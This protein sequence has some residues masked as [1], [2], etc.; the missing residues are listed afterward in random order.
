MLEFLLMAGEY[1]DKFLFCVLLA[2]IPSVAWFYIFGHKHK[3]KI[4]QI[5]ITF[6]AGMFAGAIILLYQYFWGTKFDVIFFSFEPENFD[7]NIRRAVSNTLMAS[8]FV[9]LS[10]GLL[11]EY[12]KHWV[13]KITDRGI[14]ESI[15]DVIEFSIIGALGFAFLENVGYFF[16]L[17]VNGQEE[18]LLPLFAVRSIFV[19]FVHVLCSG[20]YGYFYGLG[21]FAKPVIQDAEKSGHHKWIPN[22]LHRIFHFKKD[23]VYKEQMISLGLIVSMTLHGIYD[24]LLHIDIS[25]GRIGDSDIRLYFIVLPLIL[26]FGFGYLSYLLDKKEDQKRFGHIVTSFELKKDK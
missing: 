10:V 6:V 19:V 1:P 14:F 16:S 26:V 24:F 3:H 4:S 7:A 12:L 25:I 5:A 2:A 23:V 13:V 11:E 20:I 18:N 8:F 9:F 21:F 15:D 22:I 17:V